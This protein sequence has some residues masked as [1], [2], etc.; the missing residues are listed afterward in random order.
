MS[1]LEDNNTTKR[2]TGPQN[3]EHTS[4]EE[5]IVYKKGD[6]VC[7]WAWAGNAKRPPSSSSS[8]RGDEVIPSGGNKEQQNEDESAGADHSC[9]TSDEESE[10][11]DTIDDHVL[12]D[13]EEEEE[14]SHKGN[15]KFAAEESFL[16]QLN[17]SSE[18]KWES[19]LT[20]EN[21]A[22]YHDHEVNNDTI[23]IQDTIPISMETTKQTNIV[24][25]EEE[26]TESEES[27]A[28]SSY[29]SSKIRLN[30]ATMEGEMPSSFLFPK[31]ASSS[32]SHYLDLKFSTAEISA[33]SFAMEHRLFLRGIMELLKERD[34]V[35]V[36]AN[37]DDPMYIKAGF[38]KEKQST[39]VFWKLKYVELRKGILTFY[40]PSDPSLKRRKFIPLRAS[41]CVTCRAVKSAPPSVAK[42]TTRGGSRTTSTFVFELSVQGHP[43]LVYHLSSF[44]LYFNSSI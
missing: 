36:P 2:I 15:G 41:L 40:T 33:H 4:D 21:A 5:A 30:T 42:Y 28:D 9:T 22:S 34:L 3:E 13:L 18:D 23:S 10:D 24:Q 25:E 8:N 44:F 43:R 12:T 6:L 37:V 16:H 11:Y 35:G 27:C 20:N 14:F 1:L 29:C 7:D 38:L 39:D 31:A 26:E 19:L 32:S 17:K